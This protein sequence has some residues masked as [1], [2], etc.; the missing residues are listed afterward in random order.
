MTTRII[1]YHRRVSAP[2]AIAELTDFLVLKQEGSKWRPRRGDTIIN[3][4]C[5]ETPPQLA[6]VEGLRWV[7]APNLVKRA[8]N[9]IETFQKLTEA[10]V[11]CVKWTLDLNEARG[12]A[13]NHVVIQRNTITGRQ[14]AGIVVCKNGVLPD[15]RGHLWTR[16]FKRKEEYRVHVMNGAVIDVQRKKLKQEVADRIKAQKQAGVEAGD[17]FYIRS[18]PNGWVF[19]REGVIC[20][21]A[22][23]QASLAAIKALGLD[24]GAIDVGYSVSNSAARVFE[25]NTAPGIEGSTV[26]RYASAVVANY[27]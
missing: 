4:G 21:E 23:S 12:W 15:E 17:V 26:D 18:Y 25:A 10:S 6:A 27:S 20:P 11:P 13:K 3:W 2:R 22:V 8:V 1:T 5:T 16:Y 7:N 9:K 19:C 24:F 14:G